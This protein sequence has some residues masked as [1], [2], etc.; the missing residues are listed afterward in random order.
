MSI[1]AGGNRSICRVHGFNATE[2][3]IQE[4]AKANAQL[5]A[6]APELLESAKAALKL[7]DEMMRG[8]DEGHTAEW[9]RAAISKATGTK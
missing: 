2:S 3:F 7:L 1:T 5:I 4:E 9:L 6:A 8:H